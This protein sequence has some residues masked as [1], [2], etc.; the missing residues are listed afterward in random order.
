MVEIRRVKLRGLV[1]GHLVLDIVVRFGRT[2]KSLGGTVAYSSIALR[3]YGVDV[4]IVSKVGRDFPEEYL[5]FLARNN[6]DISY[7]KLS[8]SKSTSFKLVYDNG[9]RR[10][11]LISQCNQIFPKDLPETLDY[12]FIHIGPV[13]GEVPLSTLKK[14]RECEGIISLDV[15]GYVRRFKDGYVTYSHSYEGLR[16]LKYVDIVHGDTDEI[17]ALGGGK[18]IFKAAL[19]LLKIGP[20]ILLVTRGEKGSYIFSRDKYFYVPAPKPRKVIDPT[21]AGDVYTAIFV[22]HYI[23]SNDILESAI[24]ASA[25]ASL[26]VEEPGLS[27]VGTYDEIRG[28]AEHIREL[29]KEA[30]IPQVFE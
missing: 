13:A 4:S 19:N 5:L 14:A 17:M 8:Q 18:S 15:Q 24:M 28:R 11:F 1:I 3:R 2:R 21:G 29:V 20:M 22:A 26:L 9:Q 7:V 25:A 23:V 27:G 16:S 10:L 6:V 12:D 30:N